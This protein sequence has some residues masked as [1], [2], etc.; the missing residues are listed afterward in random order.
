MILFA[1][2]I[3]TFM[4]ALD[5]SAVNLAMPTI[6]TH[7]QVSMSM[8][9]WVI[10]SYLLIVSSLLLTFGRLS[11]LYGHKKIYITGFIIFTLG[12]LL[13]G[14]S[15]SIV[16]LIAFRVLQA[17]GA[18]MLFAAGPAI[19]TSSVPPESRGKAL[20]VTAI[21]VAL[22]LC[23]GPVIGGTL[24]T[25]LNWQSIFFINVPIGIFGSLLAFVK[26]PEQKKEKPSIP[27]DKLGSVMIFAALLLIL[28]PLNLSGSQRISTWLF[29]LLLGLGLLIILAFIAMEQH[30]KFPMLNLTLFYNRVFTASNAAALFTYMAQFMMVF[31]TPFYLQNLRGYSAFLS[32]LLYL[33]MPIATMLVAPI[34]G[35]VSDRFDSRYISSGGMLIMAAGLFCLSFLTP[36]TPIAYIMVCMFFTGIG[37]GMFQTPNNSAIMGNIPGAY[38]GVASGILATMR[39]IGMSI[40]VAIS[41]ALFSV[42]QSKGTVLYAK[43]GLSGTLL[44]HTAFAYALRITFLSAMVVALIAMTASLVKGKVKTEQEKQIE[45]SGQRESS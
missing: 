33:P 6:Q 13:C 19:I 43:R 18:G 25:I 39:N 5:S 11:D 38:R 4:S 24:T 9:E 20:S 14:L 30:I 21:A 40:G 7:F 36:S 42:C 2:G 45:R 23:A 8:A 31:L 15:V 22:G 28:L 3:G 16:M 17:L 26:I 32:G 29:L 44:S 35:I 34:S 41:G 37:F 10:T 12:S 1:V 27:F